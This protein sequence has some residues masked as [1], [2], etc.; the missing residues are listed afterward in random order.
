MSRLLSKACRVVR[1]LAL[2]LN[3]QN[4]LKFSK[5]S[6]LFHNSKTLQAQ[7]ALLGNRISH[8]FDRSVARHLEQQWIR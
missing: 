3:L 8:F 4:Y 1:E 5:C 2:M 7:L 6:V